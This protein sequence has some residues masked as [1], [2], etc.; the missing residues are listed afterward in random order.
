MT[1]APVRYPKSGVIS[2]Q[3]GLNLADNLFEVRGDEATILKNMLFRRNSLVQRYPFRNYSTTDFTADGV[4]RGAHDYKT[5]GGTARLLFY[6]NSGKIKER[7][8]ASTET[9][10]VTGLSTAIEGH[11]STVFD[12]C[13]FA[14]GQD[15]LRVGR[16]TTWRVGGSPAAVSTLAV[17]TNAGATIAEGTYLHIV[18]PV[19]EVSGVSVVF[20]NWSN[21]IRTVVAPGGIA[22]FAL[23]W[24]DIVDTRITAYLVFRTAVNATDFRSVARVATGVG[25]YTDS[26]LDTAL[27]VTV[28][29]GPSRPSPYGS[30]GVPPVAKVV[31]WSGNRLVFLNLGTGLENALQ[32]SRIAGNS[33][34]AE[35]VPANSEDGSLAPTRVR[36][37]K[38]G[39]ITCGF[40]IGETGENSTRSNNLFV[41][42]EGACFILP[43]TNPD[44]PLMEISGAIGP[45]SQRAIAQDGPFLFFQSRRGVEFW[46]GSGRD[47]Y[48]ISDKVQPIFT[49]GGSQGLTANQND[50]DIRYRVAKNQLWIQVRDDANATGPN[51]V[52][53][54][55]LLKFRRE[56]DPTNPARAVRFSGPHENEESGSG[57]GFGLL[58][59]RL[60]D[61]LICFDNQNKRILSYDETGAQDEIADVNT[62]MPVVIQHGPQ[63][64]E[65]PILQKVLHYAHVLQFTNSETTLR[66][67]AEFE[68]II[69]EATVE[70]NLYS[71]SWEDLT[72]DD[73]DWSFDTW[74]S[75]VAFD[76]ASISCKW[77]I[78]RIEK[79]DSQVDFA[80]FGLILW[81]WPF[82]QIRTLR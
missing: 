40:P 43:E 58:L 46:P 25:A 15:T 41:G 55:D 66:I 18:I 9:D 71:L 57:L 7:A 74:F 33:Y 52:Y 68:R 59:R 76:F 49:G 34:D 1:F 80:Y 28:S 6:T 45:I 65:D 61:T 36:L 82:T 48:L 10:R 29:G 16:D 78:P 38:D 54:L 14:N 47:I 63:L 17:G 50:A 30:W 51:K 24:T 62:D 4:F 56:F 5:T 31:V 70:P 73:I 2:P 32:T 27:P 69:S 19:I 79:S 23:T 26:T 42:Q 67:L 81:M 21:I 12:A 75:E 44:I 13:F 8:T 72:W 35:G 77:C 11:F 60:D 39:P 53:T 3:K 64:R 20:A 22:S 37:P